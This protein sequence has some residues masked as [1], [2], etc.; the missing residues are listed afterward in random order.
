MA[1][2]PT[3][4]HLQGLLSA[5]FGQPVRILTSDRVGGWAVARCRLEPAAGVPTSVIVKWQ[6]NDAIGWRAAARG[7]LIEQAALEFLLEVGFHSVPSLIAGDTEVVVLEDLAPMSSLADRLREQ[8]A[9]ACVPELM[10]FA[11]TAGRLAAATIGQEARYDQVARRAGA[12]GPA[13]P[14]TQ[15]DSDWPRVRRLLADLGLPMS[16]EAER[17]EAWICEALAEPGPFRAFSNGD[18]FP[19]NFLVGEGAGRLIDFEGAGFAHAMS[20]AVWIH[21]P[22]PAWI[23][24]GQTMSADLEA[25][26]REAL[27]STIPEAQDDGMFGQALAANCISWSLKRLVRF[28][29]LDARPA[30]DRSRLQMIATLELAAAAARNHRALP[31]LS[32]WCE[33]AGAWLRSRWPDSDLELSGHPA[34]EP[35]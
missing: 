32:G 8:G 18:P 6:R 34:F 27:C 19:N 35:R 11:T 23:T 5:R 17:E 3:A 16:P 26:F 9:A 4:D 13:G 29:M 12:A 2:P 7:I 31:A 22:D 30:G 24:A 33:R 21:A 25:A 15:P 10:A 14:L 1:A 28:E 20:G